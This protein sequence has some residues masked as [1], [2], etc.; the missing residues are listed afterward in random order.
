MKQ[1]RY[2]LLVAAL[3]LMV[4]CGQKKAAWTDRPVNGKALVEWSFSKDG[5]SWEKVSIPHS[6][7]AQDGHSPSYYRGTAHYKTTLPKAK[8]PRYLLFEGAVQSA[9]VFLNGE[10]LKEHSGGYTPFWVDLTG[11]LTGS[12]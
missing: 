9:Q 3:L 11:K 12:K 6:Y 2:F 7:N 10:L 4:S 8:E 5:E 1:Y